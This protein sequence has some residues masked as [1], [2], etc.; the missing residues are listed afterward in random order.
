MTCKLV[1]K[2]LW[3]YSHA[4]PIRATHVGVGELV[5]MSPRQCHITGKLQLQTACINVNVNFESIIQKLKTIV[6][7]ASGGRPC[8]LRFTRGRT[9][10]AHNLLSSHCHVSRH[11]TYVFWLW[12]LQRHRFCSAGFHVSLN[13]NAQ[14]Y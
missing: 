6:L 3:S 11:V 10:G 9:T 2:E 4:M 8:K 7:A 12:R 5:P 1:G 14:F 13:L